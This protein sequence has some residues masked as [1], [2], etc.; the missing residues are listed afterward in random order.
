MS[1]KERK[2]LYQVVEVDNNKELDFLSTEFSKMELDYIREFRIPS[3]LQYRPDLIS[4][5]F[6]GNFHM[7][8]LIALHNDFMDP[9]FD[10]KT[11]R[12]IEIP[13]L[14]DY[15]RYYKTHSRSV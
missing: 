9:I 3:I 5:K 7:G 2:F 12:L 11:G 13:N 10:F 6:F 14:D 1:I 15:F 4:K 8:W